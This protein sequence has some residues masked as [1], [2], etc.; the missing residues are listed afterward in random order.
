MSS[1]KIDVDAFID[2]SLI[3]QAEMDVAFLSYGLDKTDP[4]NIR[5]LE[6][7]SSYLKGLSKFQTSLIECNNISY[8]DLNVEQKLKQLT[9]RDNSNDDEFVRLFALAPNKYDLMYDWWI[10]ARLLDLGM[11]EAS[12]PNEHRIRLEFNRLRDAISQNNLDEVYKFSWQIS[13]HDFTNFTEEEKSIVLQALQIQSEGVAL[14]ISYS[15]IAEDKIRF[16]SWREYWNILS[17][18]KPGDDAEENFFLYSKSL[19]LQVDYGDER[20]DMSMF[21]NLPTIY[22]D[23]EFYDSDVF[24]NELDWNRKFESHEIDFILAVAISTY[25]EDRVNLITR[26]D[27]YITTNNLSLEGS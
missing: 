26:I 18:Y 12:I 25:N 23:D 15:V 9:H 22:D 20:I 16:G 24:I 4:E 14:G 3:K 21:P 11:I 17:G 7:P 5:L 27:N 8:E 2:S 6:V 19:C 13:N 1:A 10:R